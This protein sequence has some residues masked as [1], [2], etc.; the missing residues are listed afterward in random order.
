VFCSWVATSGDVL[1]NVIGI[2]TD[3]QIEKVLDCG[4]A[5]FASSEKVNPLVNQ[6]KACVFE[7]SPQKFGSRSIGPVGG[8]VTASAP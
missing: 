3:G 2:S 4:V 1:R 8:C 5:K 7:L 6:D